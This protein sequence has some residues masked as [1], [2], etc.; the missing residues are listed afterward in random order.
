MARGFEMVSNAKRFYSTLCVRS[1]VRGIQTIERHANLVLM[2]V[3]VALLYCGT[4]ELAHAG[5]GSMK[6]ACDKVLQLV[7]GAFGALVAAVAGVAAIVAAAMGGFK[8]AWTLFVI[9]IGSF[10]LRFSVSLFNG[11]CGSGSGG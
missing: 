7:E 11:Q 5:S 3:G 2:L 6:D 8:M 10:I 1:W 4:T 9:S